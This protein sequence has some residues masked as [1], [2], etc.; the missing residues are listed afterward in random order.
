MRDQFI[1]FEISWHFLFLLDIFDNVP[2]RRER[3]SLT[4]V[5]LCDCHASLSTV[6]VP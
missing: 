6:K 4:N 1:T 3:R 2:R 5:N